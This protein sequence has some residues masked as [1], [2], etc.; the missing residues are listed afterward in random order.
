MASPSLKISYWCTCSFDVLF[1]L[2][3]WI[4]VMNYLTL[5]IRVKCPDPDQFQKHT[6]W[7]NIL[8]YS[9]GALNVFIPI[10]EYAIYSLSAKWAGI[11]SNTLYILW[12]FT[13]VV[14]FVAVILLKRSLNEESKVT[15]NLKEMA[16]HLTAFSLFLAACVAYLIVGAME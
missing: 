14:L 10:I 4:F 7:I 12:I 8:Y 15:V 6:I 2:S 1:G 11:L 13:A 9:F 16:I 5:A 3:H